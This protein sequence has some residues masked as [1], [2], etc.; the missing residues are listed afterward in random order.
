M[1]LRNNNFFKITK[2]LIVLENFSDFLKNSLKSFSTPNFSQTLLNILQNSL[3]F[4]CFFKFYFIPNFIQIFSII[5]QNLSRTL[6]NVLQNPDKF[7]SK[8]T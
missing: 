6:L 8:F 4:F 3:K 7:F 1:F 2:I 5:R